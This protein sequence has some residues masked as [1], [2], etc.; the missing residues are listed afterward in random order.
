MPKLYSFSL[1]ILVLKITLNIKAATG[2]VTTVSKTFTGK[3][4]R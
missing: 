1:V 3:E 2:K 4:Q